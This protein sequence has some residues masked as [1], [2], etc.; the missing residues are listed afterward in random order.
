M[1][2]NSGIKA[3]VFIRKIGFILCVIIL[4][5]VESSYTF[6]LCFRNE[7]N[8]EEGQPGMAWPPAKGRSAVSRPTTRGGRPQGQQ[9]TRGDHPQ[10]QQLPAGTTSC[11]QAPYKGRPLQQL[12]NRKATCGQKHGPLPAANPGAAPTKAP[13]AGTAP[14]VGAAASGQVQRHRLR[15]A[16]T[17]AAVQMGARGL[18]YPFRKRMILPL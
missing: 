8:E 15:R 6:L 7:G 5:R 11:G 9:P 13:L 2:P 18:G 1:F 12:A 16:V 3:K 4:N 14:A 17:V 10:G